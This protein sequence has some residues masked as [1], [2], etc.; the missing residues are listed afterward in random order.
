MIRFEWDIVKAR[1]NEEKHGV[2]F[3]E[4]ST[5]FRDPLSLTIWDAAHSL[6]ED[7]YITLGRTSND[8]LIV[9]V[10]SD[11]GEDTIRLISARPAAQREIKEY[12][13]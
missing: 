6:T 8:R 7:R 1:T 13:R 5:V 9:V 3:K 2:S 12:E 4:A 10:H 11:I